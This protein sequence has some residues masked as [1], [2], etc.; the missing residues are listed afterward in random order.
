MFLV[1]GLHNDADSKLDKLVKIKSSIIDFADKIEFLPI[2]SLRPIDNALLRLNEIINN[3]DYIVLVS[4]SCIDFA[5]AAILNAFKPDFMVMGSYSFNLLRKLTTQK[6]LYPINVSGVNGLIGEIITVL[7]LQAKKVLL[8]K[9]AA[10][11]NNM[12]LNTMLECGADVTKLN[13][14]TTNLPLYSQDILIKVTNIDYYEGLVV[15][16]SSIVSWL[17]A[18]AQANGYLE[19]LRVVRFIT[20]HKGIA[21]RLWQHGAL[22]VELI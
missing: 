1:C 14:Y 21:E 20:W 19:M 9:G 6:I 17:F 22:H 18:E 16:S 3:F 4:P 12:L 13:I 7:E 10:N 8:V 15:T 11:D 2:I 5:K